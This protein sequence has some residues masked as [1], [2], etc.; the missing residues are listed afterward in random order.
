MRSNLPPDEFFE[1][2]KK[3]S[4]LQA[5]LDDLDN[6][7]EEQLSELT[8]QPL[9]IREVLVRKKQKKHSLTPS[10]IAAMM[11]KTSANPEPTGEV[12]EWGFESGWLRYGN[13]QIEVNPG[14]P[15]M[16]IDANRCYVGPTLAKAA[17]GAQQAINAGALTLGTMTRSQYQA[18]HRAYLT[19]RHA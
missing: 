4:A 9:W 19:K 10:Q 18:R 17:N 16:V 1:R 14:E 7:T 8:G 5:I 3:K 2:M 15:I 13:V 11:N 6:Y 12:F